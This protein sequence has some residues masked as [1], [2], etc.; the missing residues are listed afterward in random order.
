MQ[1]VAWEDPRIAEAFAGGRPPGDDALR[2]LLNLAEK[3][4][5]RKDGTQG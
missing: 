2:E 3:G 1:P 5:G 4:G